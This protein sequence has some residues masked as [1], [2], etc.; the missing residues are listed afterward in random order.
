[1]RDGEKGRYALRSARPEEVDE[2]FSLYE[3]R[4]RWMDEKGIRQWND[5]DYLNAYP[6]D[7]Y[8]EMREKD[9][10]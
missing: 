6:A 7:Y 9:C 8:R 10:L 3:K 4:V 1:M 2:V 5:T